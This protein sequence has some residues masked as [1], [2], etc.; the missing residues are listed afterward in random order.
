MLLFYQTEIQQAIVQEATKLRSS[1]TDVDEALGVIEDLL[2]KLRLLA[3]EVIA[4]RYFVQ[5]HC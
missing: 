1:A 4:R 2:K 3:V 5:S